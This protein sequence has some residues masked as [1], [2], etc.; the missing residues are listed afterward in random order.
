MYK[1]ISNKKEFSISAEKENNVFS[2]NDNNVALDIKKLSERAFHVLR[3]NKGYQVELVHLDK[4]AKSVSLKVNGSI[5]N[6]TLKDEMDLLLQKMG[7]NDIT[8]AKVSEVKAPMPGLVL[9]V[10][11]H[12]GDTV[13]KGDALVILEA[14]KMENVIKSPI[15]GEV[16]AI[17]VK[18]GEPVEKNQILIQFK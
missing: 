4:A 13:K 12:E 8:V 10:V 18:N 14:M 5:Y 2:V 15:D 9:E 11:A 16:K 1:V 3:D 6:Y 17:K 7:L